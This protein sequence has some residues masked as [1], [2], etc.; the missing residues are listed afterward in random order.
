MMRR[1][2]KRNRGIGGPIIPGLMTI[3]ALAISPGLAVE[4]GTLVGRVLDVVSKK[5]IS[6]AK[7][8]VEGTSLSAVTDDAGEYVIPVI[9]AGTY[10]LTFSAR[11]FKS[12]KIPE[13]LVLAGQVTVQDVEMVGTPYDVE[14][15]VRVEADYFKKKAEEPLSQFHLDR[16]EI[17]RMAGSIEDISRVLNLF[18]SVARVSE[19]F[20]DLI[21]RGGSPFENGFYVDGIPVANINYFQREGGSGGALGIL[22]TDLIETVDFSSGGFSAVYGDRLSSIVDIKFRRGKTDKVAARA[23][24]N[25]SGLGLSVEGPLPGGKGSWIISGKRSYYD[26]LAKVLDI[27]IV[28]NLGNIHAKADFRL[29]PRDRITVLDIFGTCRLAYGIDIAVEKDMNYATNARTSQNTLGIVWQH[30][31]GDLGYSE[32]SVSGSY[33]K[34]LDTLDDPFLG[35]SYLGRDEDELTLTLRN[36]NVIRFDARNKIEFGFETRAVRASFNNY[37]SSYV[38]KWGLEFP[39]L[40]INGRFRESLSGVFASHR[41]SLSERLSFVIGLRGDYFTFNRS[42]HVSPRASFTWNVSRRLTLNFGGGLFRQTLY[43]LLLVRNPQSASLKDPLAIHM[44]A[45]ADI[46]LSESAKMTLEFY[47]KDYQNLPQTPDDP[48][49]FILDNNVAMTGYFQ[50]QRLADGGRATSRGVEL[51]LQKKFGDRVSAVVSASLFRAQFRDF[52]GVWRDRLYDNRVLLTLIGRFR[53]DER[54]DVNVRWNFSGG[55]PYTPFDLEKSMAANIGI[56]DRSKYF[57]ERYP[58]YHSLFVRVDRR[59]VFR[60]AVLSVYL[61]LINAYDHEN[62]TRYYWNRTGKTVSAVNQARLIPVFG[63]ELEF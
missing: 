3:L 10:S 32:T 31:W 12:Y 4:A 15:M 46:R 51:F 24:L 22:N 5:S 39:G 2:H 29:T 40:Q 9:P 60:K 54:W 63:V 42:V 27:G 41:I 44:I 26:I 11:G 30:L 43:P 49:L 33:V 6:H 8:V 20:N 25:I 18:P 13:R 47:V 61:S 52:N 53:P 28:P 14:E 21:V 19:L 37:Y 48:T 34:D 55:I 23:D 62:I 56:L 45:G 35:R 59:F 7:I 1:I 57:A 17:N 58:G 50:Y 36:V 16:T 38:D